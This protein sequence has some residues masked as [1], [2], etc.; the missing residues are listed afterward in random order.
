[1]NSFSHATVA[2]MDL[3]QARDLFD[4]VNE[5]LA[6]KPNIN[7]NYWCSLKD[8]LLIRINELLTAAPSIR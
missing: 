1:M 6:T 5:I 3:R 4:G 8:A 2:H 7:V